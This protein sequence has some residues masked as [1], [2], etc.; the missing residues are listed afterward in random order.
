MIAHVAESGENRGRVVLQLGSAHPSAVALQA[1]VRVARAFQAEIESVFVED[2]QLFDCAAY[3]FVREVS[4]SGRRSRTVSALQMSEGLRLAAQ[5]ARRQIEALARLSDVP[6][7]SRVVRDEPLRAMAV[8]C[9][10]TGPWNVLALGE[11]FAGGNAALVKQLLIEISGTTGVVMVGP[12]ARHVTGPAVIAVEDMNSLP[13]LLRA[14]ERLTALDGGQIVLLLIAPDEDALG[15][16][17]EQ[18]RLVVEAREDV[19]IEMAA[20]ARGEAAVVAEAL[21]RLNG[22]F[23]IC[24]FGGLVVPDEGDLRPLASVLECPLF[25]VR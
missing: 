24:Q 18:S 2:A 11:P 15:R 10:E 16:M 3:S 20:M 1:A 25:L 22:G 14:A 17:D 9:A 6:L 13:A 8:A 7:R 23:V 12:R 5:A 4:L 21:R 19:R